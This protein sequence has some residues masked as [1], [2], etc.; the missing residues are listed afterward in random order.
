MKFFL[1]VREMLRPFFKFFFRYRAENKEN[2]P[3]TA[4]IACINHVALRD[5]P[6]AACCL[7]GPVRFV[8]KSE[9]GKNP[10]LRCVL[11][12]LNVIYVDREK[13]DIGSIRQCVDSIKSG[14]NVGIFPQGTRVREKALPEQAQEG[15]ALICSLTKAP[16]LPVA[17][18]YKSGRPRLFSPCRVIIGKPVYP[19]EYK[20]AGDRAAQSRYIFGKVCELIDNG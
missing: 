10:V 6:I 20:S 3:D 19:E 4:Y 9:L 7:K 12:L 17:L 1:I 13:A 8:C 14:L 16:V 2:I 15:I 18:V 5:A 11:N